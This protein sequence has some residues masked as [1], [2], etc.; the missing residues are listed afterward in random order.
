MIDSA[1]HF[2]TL[3][4]IRSI[5]D[6]LPYAKIN[7]LH[8]HMVDS[9][10]FPFQSKTYPDLW[11]GAYSAEERYTQDDIATIVEYARLRG[12]RVY[13]EF[14]VPG[15]AQS[16]CVGVPEICPSATC[17]TPL[18]VANNKTFDV[19]DGLLEE[20][21]GGK[22]S[23]RGSPS[24]LF[25]DNFVHLGGDEV[26]TSCWGST[27]DIQ[28]WLNKTNR[29]ADDG[30]AYF[31]HRASEIAISKGRRPIQWSEV[32]DHFKTDL[33][34]KT[35]VHIWK[36]NTNVTEV[37]ANG[38]NVLLNVGDVQNSWYLD[39]LN[40]NFSAVYLNEPCAG[41]PDDLCSLI[42]GGNGEM[43]GETVDASDLEQT[44]WPREA[45]IAE[46]LWSPASKTVDPEAAIPRAQQF[47]C[48]LNRRGVRAAPVLNA[49][50]RSAP[51]GPGPCATQ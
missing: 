4:A 24:G 51:P 44:V 32:Y 13:V 35:V 25:P 30:Y 3:D 38:Y 31:A 5:I 18:N 48:L 7:T 22:S 17:T 40:V 34:K 37:L 46:K 1:R 10:S 20:C 6:S 42:L 36:S 23:V 45:A 49:N 14:D 15:H 19:I 12:V 47:R 26:D 8:W 2:E 28:A 21:T 11:K 27:P 43:W 50:A 41:I 29:T 9:Q 16:W 33:D 39:H